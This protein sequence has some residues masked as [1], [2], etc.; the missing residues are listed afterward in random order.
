[1]EGVLVLILF[2][3]ISSKVKI[4]EQ[5]PVGTLLYDAHSKKELQCV[6]IWTLGICQCFC[7]ILN[8]EGWDSFELPAVLFVKRRNYFS[9]VFFNQCAATRI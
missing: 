8:L 9:T 6:T 3:V 1:M 2:H 5:I 7:S 4:P